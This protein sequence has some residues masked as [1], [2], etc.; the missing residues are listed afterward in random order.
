MVN[1]NYYKGRLPISSIVKDHL[2]Y[3]IL[4]I[5][6][7]DVFKSTFID[8]NWGEIKI[9]SCLNIFIPLMKIYVDKREF[10]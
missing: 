3:S 8:K 5:K 9:L 10:I 2:H 1:R 6:Y 7:D 4:K